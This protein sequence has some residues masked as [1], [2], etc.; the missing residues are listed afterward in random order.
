MSGLLDLLLL[1]LFS[2]LTAELARLC[3][4]LLVVVAA[5]ED[6]PATVP[7]LLRSVLEQLLCMVLMSAAEECY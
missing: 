4:L 6:M 5:V 1:L 3:D 7:V 2:G